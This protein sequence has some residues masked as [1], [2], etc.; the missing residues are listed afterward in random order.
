MSYKFKPFTN[1]TVEKFQSKNPKEGDVLP[2]GKSWCNHCDNIPHECTCEW[3]YITGGSD[4]GW[5]NDTELCAGEE[6]TINR[7]VRS[8]RREK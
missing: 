2:N 6:E 8:S 4:E 7:S 1:I 5:I 3:M